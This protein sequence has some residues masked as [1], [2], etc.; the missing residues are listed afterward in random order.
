MTDDDIADFHGAFGDP[1]DPVRFPQASVYTTSPSYRPTPPCRA[2]TCPGGSD[3]YSLDVAA[4]RLYQALKQRDIP[5]TL[6]GRAGDDHGWQF[7][8]DDLGAVLAFA[9]AALQAESEV[10]GQ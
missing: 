3:Q 4:L 5:A 6:V 9:S 1:F 10:A 8:H 2:S 7:W